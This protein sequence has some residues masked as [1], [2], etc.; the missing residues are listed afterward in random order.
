V[1]S[2]SFNSARSAANE[3]MG[4]RLGQRAIRRQHNGSMTLCVFLPAVAET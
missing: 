4:F 1:L 2:K 3:M